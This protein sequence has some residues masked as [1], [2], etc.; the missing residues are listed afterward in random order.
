MPPSHPPHPPLTPPPQK[1]KKKKK[2]T[3]PCSR[4]SLQGEANKS[5][6]S[7]YYST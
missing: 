3:F 2:K 1:K 6:N 4:L 7:Q 5:I